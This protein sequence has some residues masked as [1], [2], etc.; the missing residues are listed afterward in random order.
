[1]KRLLYLIVGFIVAACGSSLS[2]GSTPNAPTGSPTVSTPA[3]TAT[4]TSNS[5]PTA[6][7]LPS[8]TP[9]DMLTGKHAEVV[10]VGA[11]G[12]VYMLQAEGIRN[13]PA[14]NLPPLIAP[15]LLALSK[16]GTLRSDW[17]PAALPAGDG[18]AT[19]VAGDGTIFVATEGPS[20]SIAITAI[21]P[22]GTTAGT[23]RTPS[24]PPN[25]LGPN[26]PFLFVGSGA[27]VCLAVYD[28][29]GAYMSAYCLS[30]DAKLLPGWPYKSSGGSSGQLK[31]LALGG[32]GTLYLAREDDHPGILALGWDGKVKPG[33]AAY[34][35]M[36]YLNAGAL[37]P[38]GSLYLVR[39]Y[40][41]NGQPA[42][43]SLVALGPDG[44][45]RTGWAAPQIE[46]GR[47]IS[48]IVCAPDSTLFVSTTKPASA[49]AD[50]A[51]A[52]GQVLALGPDG[53]PRTGWPFAVADAI[54]GGVQLSLDG[55]VWIYD[56]D[57][58]NQHCTVVR[59]DGTRTGSFQGLGP[60]VFDASG[61]GYLVQFKD[62][63][64]RVVRLG[65][66]GQTS[67]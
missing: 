37:C 20:N 62:G 21:H 40:E 46:S 41:I 16:T 43:T 12:T 59:P 25:V 30:S 5:T 50:Y 32:D 22:D 55:S 29:A 26:G 36:Q 48:G 15:K 9:F 7:P 47:E 53:S 23:Y 66:S 54:V 1:M 14:Y 35:A 44:K 24:V 52:A 28:P 42:S 3:A 58:T 17:G 39:N 51:T 18:L 45:P 2:T 34:T 67:P 63:G 8:W 38:D 56:W 27:G 31:L 13:P 49:Q 65:P 10:G 61:F 4:A 60:Q 33:W 6:S 57:G 11:D 19:A 64:S